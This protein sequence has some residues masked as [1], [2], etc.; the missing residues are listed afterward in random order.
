MV[1]RLVR[2]E[3]LLAE[4]QTPMEI[5]VAIAPGLRVVL[6]PTHPMVERVEM[7]VLTVSEA[8]EMRPV[9]A[10][11]VAATLHPE[12]VADRV[13]TF[14]KLSAPLLWRLEHL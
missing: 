8:P 9:V 5:R 11:P 10:V 2:V 6:V 4:P 3:Q 14:R 13:L 7:P 1:E 12:A